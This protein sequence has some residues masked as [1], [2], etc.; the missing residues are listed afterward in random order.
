[1]SFVS[2]RFS[3]KLV[4]RR[5]VNLSAFEDLCPSIFARD[6]QERPFAIGRSHGTFV[7]REGNNWA[8]T[9]ISRIEI[10]ESKLLS[11]IVLM[12]LE[13]VRNRLKTLAFGMIGKG[14]GS[15]R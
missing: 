13:R 8:S 5:Y 11:V 9:E 14:S 7:A 12:F 4:E 2:I 6:R 10:D 1:M 15:R 3:A